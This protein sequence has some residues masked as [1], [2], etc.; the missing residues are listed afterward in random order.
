MH[1]IINLLLPIVRGIGFLM[2]L[3]PATYQALARQS[4]YWPSRIIDGEIDNGSDRS[5]GKRKGSNKG[6]GAKD[7]KHMKCL[8]SIKLSIYN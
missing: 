8:R 1:F 4:K 7:V 2:P 3:L 6:L 5:I